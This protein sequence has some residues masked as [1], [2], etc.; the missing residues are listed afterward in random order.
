MRNNTIT[1]KKDERE[2]KKNMEDPPLQ[3]SINF[4]FA[5]PSPTKKRKKREQTKLTDERVREGE[6]ER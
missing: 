5:S 4:S 3:C 2:R 1:N 6:R